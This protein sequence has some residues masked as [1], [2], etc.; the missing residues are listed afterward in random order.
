MQISKKKWGRLL[1]YLYIYFSGP[2]CQS[3]RGGLLNCTHRARAV[4]SSLFTSNQDTETHM[5]LK[6]IKIGEIGA[7]LGM[8]SV[9]NGFLGFENVRIPRE[10]HA[11]EERSGPGRWNLCKGPVQ[12]ADLRYDGV[13][14]RGDCQGH[15]PVLGQGG[16]DCHQVLGRQEAESDQSKVKERFWG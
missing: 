6:G 11:D 8:N 14:P 4:E 2:H 12:C 16:N 1:N 9:N 5:P 3:L 10:E 7:K 13:C 15:E